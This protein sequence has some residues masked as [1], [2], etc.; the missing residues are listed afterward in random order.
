MQCETAYH[1]V[2]LLAKHRHSDVAATLK[3]LNEIILLS[4]HVVRGPNRVVVVV[5]GVVVA[6]VVVVVVVVIRK[7]ELF[8]TLSCSR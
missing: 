4:Q 2:R 1:Q 7:V 6:V 3:L 8:E 5:I